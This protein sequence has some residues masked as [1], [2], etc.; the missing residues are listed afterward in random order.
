MSDSGTVHDV[1]PTAPRWTHIALRVQD[2]DA[3]IAW[4]TE[5]TPLELLERRQ[6]DDGFGAWL[7]HAEPA[8]NPFILVLA[9][10]LPESDPFAGTPYALLT[11]FA[12]IGIE[13]TSRTDIEDMAA[14]GEAA[15]CLGMPPTEMPAPIGYI[16][17][18]KDPDGNTVEYSFDQGVYAKAREVWG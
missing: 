16:C 8:E 7:G 1:H 10:F 11:P 18:L 17:M 14:K 2:I 5:F 3:S 9:Q 4:Y 6:D 15:G 12:H 13:M